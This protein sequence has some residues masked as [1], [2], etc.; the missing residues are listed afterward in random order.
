[1]KMCHKCRKAVPDNE[2]FCPSCGQ[3]VKSRSGLGLAARFFSAIL[4]T[5]A[6]IILGAFGACV[7][8]VVNGSGTTRLSIVIVVVIV[9]WGLSM[10]ALFRKK[11]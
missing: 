3:Y 1:M 6:S 5:L 4:I 11:K 8:S 2:A 9:V 10:W 7:T